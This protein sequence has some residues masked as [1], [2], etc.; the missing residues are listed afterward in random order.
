MEMT[1]S[2][3]RFALATYFMKRGDR[4]RSSQAF[5]VSSWASPSIEPSVAAS[6]EDEAEDESKDCD[7][8]SSDVVLTHVSNLRQ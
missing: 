6:D 3:M 8:D 7:S 2:V 1:S 5:D 4:S